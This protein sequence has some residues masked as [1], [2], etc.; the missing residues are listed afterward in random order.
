M[1][2]PCFRPS[3]M[4]TTD[5]AGCWCSI[6]G[7]RVRTPLSVQAENIDGVTAD[8]GARVITVRPDGGPTV[9]PASAPG[10]ER[11][12]WRRRAD[13]P[14]RCVSAMFETPVTDAE[15]VANDQT[16]VR[17]EH[18]RTHHSTGTSIRAS[19]STISICRTG[20]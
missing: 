2:Q 20:A 3:A 8:L 13:E 1:F 16:A 6:S 10:D 9:E 12:A 5:M 7:S 14:V 11:E 15:G 4:G 18:R 19:G 17:L